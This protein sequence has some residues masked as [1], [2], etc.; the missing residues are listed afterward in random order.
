MLKIRAQQIESLQGGVNRDFARRISPGIRDGFPDETSEFGDQELL[1]Y[2]EGTIA[3]AQGYG[4]ATDNELVT[5]VQLTLTVAEDFDT[6][7][8]FKKT[9]TDESIDNDRRLDEMFRRTTDDDWLEAS[10]YTDDSGE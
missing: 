9:F 8:V 2:I 7:G 1:E 5:F 6:K 10:G 3:R 4:L